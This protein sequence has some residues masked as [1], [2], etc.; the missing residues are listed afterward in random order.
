MIDY[1]KEE[2]DR[3]TGSKLTVPRINPADSVV[4]EWVMVDM[5][6]EVSMVE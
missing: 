5:V 3:A 2:P 1:H 4:G 6:K